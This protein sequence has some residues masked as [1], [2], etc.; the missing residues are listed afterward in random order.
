MPNVKTNLNLLLYLVLVQE[1]GWM[2]WWLTGQQWHQFR[3]RF[4]QSLPLPKVFLW[5]RMVSGPVLASGVLTDNR[6]GWFA[7]FRSL[8]VRSSIPLL[9][10]QASKTTT[11]VESVP[12]YLHGCPPLLSVPS[13]FLYVPPL[14]RPGPNLCSKS[15]FFVLAEWSWAISYFAT[16]TA[17]PFLSY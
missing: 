10:M 3:W 6:L 14:S 17:P 16:E 11:N 1:S 13:F 9:P 7:W 12:F 2:F 5:C 8:P 4:G 15:E